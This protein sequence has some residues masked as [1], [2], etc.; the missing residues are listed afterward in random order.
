MCRLCFFYILFFYSLSF[1]QEINYYDSADNLTGEDLKSALHDLIDDHIEYDYNTIKDI[2]KQTDSDPDN[3]NNIILT[4]TGNSINKSNFA[5]SGQSDYWNREHVWAKSHGNFGFDGDWGEYGANT[6]AHHLKPVDSSIN[7]IRSN[8]DFDNG[9]ELVFN[10]IYET[11]CYVSDYSFEPRDEVKGDVARMIFYMDLR[12]DGGVLE[13]DLEVVDY[14]SLEESYPSPEMGRLSTLLQ[15]HEDDPPDAFERNR[16]E[17][18]YS[19]QGNRNPFIDRPE[20]V[21]YIYSDSFQLNPIIIENISLEYSNESNSVIINLELNSE[22]ECTE[23]HLVTINYGNNWFNLNDQQNFLLDEGV[24]LSEIENYIDSYLFYEITISNCNQIYSYYGSMKL[25]ELLSLKGILDFSVPLGGD[26]GKAVH[27][28]ANQNIPDLSIYAIGIANNGGGTDG[29]EYTFP[30]ISISKNEHI[31]IANSSEAMSSYFGDCYEYFS[32]IFDSNISLN[33][34]D[35][36][37]L[38]YGENVIQTFG[39][40]NIDGTGEN[41]EYLDS[42]AY[43]NQEGNWIFGELN[44]T[45]N[46]ESIQSSDCLYPICSEVFGCTDENASNYNMDATEMDNSCVFTSYQD[47]NLEEGWGIFSTYITPLDSNLESIFGSLEDVIIIKDSEG[48]A[49]WP[50]FDLNT[51]GSLEPGKG[52]QIKMNSNQMITLEGDKI[53]YNYEI[54]LNDGWGIIAYLHEESIDAN[55]M[56][57]SIIDDIDI[58]KDSEGNALWPLFNLNTIGDLQPG[59]GYQIKMLNTIN[60]QYPPTD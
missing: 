39:D 15:W 60:F 3:P 46:T 13:P 59:K 25:F 12:Y 57:N 29:Q 40:I 53:N 7:S 35:A 8:K 5:S 44:C 51:I 43:L 20:F 47:I 55:V 54:L 14:I 48:N 36:V 41:W 52:Y 21:N 33:G 28:V 42:W 50:F 45:D 9:G 4:Y 30:S 22:L 38:F 56:F 31:L 58:V 18:I 16:N 34:D 26:N 19:W 17:I 23:D 2:L 27:L 1:S 32:H 10:G 49:F 11:D 24:F 6:D 37:E